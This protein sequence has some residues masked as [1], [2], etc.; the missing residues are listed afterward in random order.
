MNASHAQIRRFC[1][2]NKVVAMALLKALEGLKQGQVFPLTEECV[3]I[4]R[5]PDCD[6]VLEAGAVSRQHARLVRIGEEYYLEDLHSRNKTYLN[7]GEVAER[8]KLA[9]GDRIKICDLVFTYHPNLDL[10]A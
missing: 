4:G 5:H 3:T 10:G 6:I 1:P 9:D 2:T 8:R 7:D